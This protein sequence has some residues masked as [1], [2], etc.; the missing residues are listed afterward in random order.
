MYISRYLSPGPLEY[1]VGVIVTRWRALLLCPCSVWHLGTL[2]V[3]AAIPVDRML[4]RNLPAVYTM[5]CLKEELCTVC[6]NMCAL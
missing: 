4:H 5:T 2:F 6:A 3:L 1:E